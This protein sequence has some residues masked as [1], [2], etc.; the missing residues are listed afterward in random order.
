MDRTIEIKKKIA[1]IYGIHEYLDN[2]RFY[3]K[4]R[5]HNK[6]LDALGELFGF[7]SDQPNTLR[8]AMEYIDTL[9][10]ANFKGFVI[11]YLQRSSAYYCLLATTDII[12]ALESMNKR[13]THLEQK[14][15]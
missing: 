5:I 14:G 2:A 15:D 12:K 10:D 11:R 4:H 1:S 6:S 13:L 8:L 9:N 7:A 3:Y